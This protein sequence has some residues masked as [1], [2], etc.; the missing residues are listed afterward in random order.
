[1]ENTEHQLTDSVFSNLEG[2]C[3][4]C[5]EE[6]ASQI[7][8]AISALPLRSVHW[9]GTGDYH[10]LSLFW[11]ERIGEPFVL[12][13]FDN[14]PDDQDAAF[15]GGLLS[16]G[17]WVRQVRA[18]PFCKGVVW[19]DGKGRVHGDLKASAELPAYLSVDLDVLDVAYART[20]WDQ[21]SVSLGALLG[22]IGS[23][24]AER[25]I[26]GADICGGLTESECASC[27]LERNGATVREISA[28]ISKALVQAA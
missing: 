13:L 27:D 22:A 12:I 23:I 5:S 8:Q 14:H 16:C 24:T 6:S 17:G 4:Y 26:I 15:G 10:Y 21:G 25:R 20:N 3:R 7:R 19:F 9:I 11:A 2:T 28:L 1:M 18:L